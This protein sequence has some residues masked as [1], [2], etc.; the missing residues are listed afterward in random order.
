MRTL[1]IDIASHHGLL[2]LC[3]EKKIVASQTIDHQI[4]DPELI[5][6]TKEILKKA[7]WKPS[8]LTHLAC[9]I[10]PGG[11]TS[12]RVGVAFANALAWSLKIPI[13]GI[14]LSDLYAARVS[15]PLSPGEREYSFLWL[16]ST[17]K[18]ELFVRGFG[19][20]SK[21]W[22]EPMHVRLE[23]IPGSMYWVG[24]LLPE[25][26][27]PSWKEMPL[28]RIEHV[29]PRFLQ[30]RIYTEEILQPWYGRKG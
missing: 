17:K 26:I 9:V 10:G 29:L 15:D 1:F 6:Q 8:D 16:H 18:N 27:H 23:E 19:K 3:M 4:R 11:F 22:R 5:L 21:M 28:E 24:E 30:E 14:H 2:A 20:Y 7:R 25:H 13:T 12:L